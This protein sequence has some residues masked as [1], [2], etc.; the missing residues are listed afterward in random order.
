MEQPIITYPC[1]WS[2]RLIC[3]DCE[4]IMKEVPG[5]MGNIKHE[6][7][8]VNRSKQGKYVSVNIEAVVNSDDERLSI[9]P[10]LMSIPTV[11]MVL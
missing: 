3:E 1:N 6:I 10:K 7:S 4:L 5:K 2:Y 8:P 9:A 11:R